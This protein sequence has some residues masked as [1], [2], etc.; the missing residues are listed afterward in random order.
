M[1]KLFFTLA[2]LSSSLLAFG[3]GQTGHRVVAQIAHNHLSKNAQKALHDIMGHESLVEASTWMD[4]I[5]SDDA[6]DHT[7]TWHYVTIP[8]GQT[9]ASSE[10]SESGDAY[11]M[12]QRMIKVL[13][14]EAADL[15]AKQEAVRMLVHVIGDIHQPLHVGNGDDRGGNDVKINWFYK[16]SNLH[17]IWD[18][19]M[20]DSKGFSYSE[21]AKLIDHPHEEKGQHFHSTDLDLWMKEA[22]DL[23]TQ[24]YTLDDEENLSYK[25]LYLNW[26]TVKDQLY[27]A[28]IRLASVFNEIYG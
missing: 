21:L 5:K 14:D 4:N 27:K 20:I 24:V 23:R 16:S 28:G 15:K 7:H 6:Y 13:K 1:K 18:S 2:I 19:G 10:K 22:M 12:I 3:W 9:Y 8:D 26:E 11:E 25:Y 17:R